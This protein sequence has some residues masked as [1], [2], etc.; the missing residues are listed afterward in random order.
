VNHSSATAATTS[1]F[2]M[3]QSWK[4]SGLMAMAIHQAAYTPASVHR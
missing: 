1:A 2:S 4:N 3:S